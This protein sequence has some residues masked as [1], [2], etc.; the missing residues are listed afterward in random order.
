MTGERE[1]TL[2]R[3]VDALS[4][5]QRA[6]LSEALAAEMQ[7]A[8]RLVAFVV[9]DG[10]ATVSG[11]A[12]R[13]FLAERLSEF[14][15]PAHFVVLDA[16]PRTV[17]GKLD[18]AALARKAPTDQREAQLPPAVVAEITELESQLIAIWRDVLKT[19]AINVADDFFEI[20]GDSLLSI[21]VISRAARAGIRISP[22]QFFERPTIRHI[23]ASLT[24]ES[25]RTGGGHSAASEPKPVP[26]AVGEAPL[27]PIQHWFLEAIPEHRDWW[28]QSYVLDAGHALDAAQ[29]RRLIGVLVERHSALRLRLARRDGRWRQE[30][31]A[32]DDAV[33]FRS[34]VVDDRDPAQRSVRIAEEGEREHQSLRLDQGRLF[35]CVLLES[36][37]GWRRLLLVAHHVIVDAVSW[38]V[39]LEDL[40]TLVV[41]SVSGEPL[42]LPPATMSPRAWALALAEQANTPT[43]QSFGHHWLTMPIEGGSMPADSGDNSETVA[44]RSRDA[45]IVTIM[46][47]GDATRRLVQ[48]APRRMRSSVSSLLLA[49][50]LLAWKRW[51][52]TDVLRLDLEGLGRDLLGDAYDVSRTVGWFT[53]VFPMRLAVPRAELSGNEATV[54]AIIASVQ[55]SL[56]ALPWRGAAHGVIRYLSNDRRAADALAA[57]PRPSLLFNYLGAYDLTLPPA[58]MLRVSGEPSGRQR[59]PDAMRP[60]V[61]ELNGRVQDGR[62]IVD[63]EYSRATHLTSTIEHFATL[64]RESLMTV[65]DAPSA[66]TA[67]AGLDAASLDTV[68]ELLGALDDD[69]G[70]GR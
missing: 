45:A 21:R 20:G 31:Q 3:R 42:R 15:I 34:V 8:G 33:P 10:A 63:I 70:N 69:D 7:I 53:T 36:P 59:S 57:L 5:T 62:L 54:G 4:A 68:A 40:A 18:R 39:I 19:D 1:R 6:T 44:G 49:A 17:V 51:S 64:L 67:T 22:E 30:F 56:D 13:A 50:L 55:G 37:V 58:A 52:G 43:I 24:V 35:R 9:A 29:W 27:S 66:R 12:M 46:L 26:D 32:P 14:M 61:L 65:S 16:L 47:G 28:N 48:D 11:D 41:Q 38:S 23:A 2:R 60:Y 25:A